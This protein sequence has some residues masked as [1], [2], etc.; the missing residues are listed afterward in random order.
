[1]N[2]NQRQKY[3]HPISPRFAKHATPKELEEKNVAIIDYSVDKPAL[4]R[5]GNEGH[6]WYDIREGLRYQNEA[7]R[8]RAIADVYRR[9]TPRW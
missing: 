3:T 4:Q 2:N 6:E 9:L 1:V 8:Q 5:K 7:E